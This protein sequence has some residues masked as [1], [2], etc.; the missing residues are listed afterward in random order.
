MH[1][2]WL[3]AS[4][5]LGSAA[6]VAEP[7]P[8][9]GPHTPVDTGTPT[10]DTYEP[11]PPAPWEVSYVAYRFVFGT[12]PEGVLLPVEGYFGTLAPTFTVLLLSDGYFA[13]DAD[14]ICHLDIPLEGAR[15]LPTPLGANYA[16]WEVDADALG[17]V[18]GCAGL[19]EGFYGYDPADFWGTG[20]YTISI[21][22]F[23]AE[24]WE[25]YTTGATGGTD[26]GGSVQDPH[27]PS[28]PTTEP[29][30]FPV[31]TAAWPLDAAGY[32]DYYGNRLLAAEVPAPGGGVSP[33]FYYGSTL[34]YAL[35]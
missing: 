35:Y 17:V 1:T 31:S 18:D 16:S 9:D 26:S 20:V 3:A 21:G 15:P 2:A 27:F 32:Y 28:A 23:D 19:T 12:D 33:G 8:G 30:G 29:S 14:E 13:G 5:F 4:A 22:P 25:P 7:E 11:P 10:H 24:F 6:C 34:G